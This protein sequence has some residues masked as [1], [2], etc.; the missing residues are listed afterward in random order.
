[1]AQKTIN[2]QPLEQ[3]VLTYLQ[4]H[5]MMSRGD[6]IVVAVSGG[7]DSVCL[8][9]ILHSLCPA[10]GIK[11]QVAHLDH[12][13]RGTESEADALYVAKLVK[14]L[15]IPATIEKRDVK[16]YRKRH[17]ISL[18]EA[19]REVRY[20]FLA[21]VVANTGAGCI[22]VGHTQNDNVETIL[23]HLIRGTGM[24][25]LRGLQP[26]TRWKLN[27][28]NLTVVRP[29][30]EIS[31]EE[32]LSYCARH[33]LHPR[34]DST[35]LSLAPLRN[36]IR[37]ELLP[38]LKRY[39][40]QVVTAILRTAHLAGDDIA[41]LEKHAAD[42]WRRVASKQ[43]DS[44][45]LDKESLR[46]LHPSL[47][48]YI[49]RLALEKQ[50]GNLKDIEAR[51]VEELLESFN[52]PAGKQISLPYGLVFSIDYD[53]YILAKET[54][55]LSP[56]P[57]I[58]GEYPVNIPGQ[59]VVPGWY[60]QADIMSPGETIPSD[61]NFTAY[62]DFSRTGK[63]L[64]IRPR[65]R[66]DR[67]QPLGMEETKK[68][69]DFMLDARISKDWRPHVPILCAG[70]KVLWVSGYRISESVKITNRT[71]QILRIKLERVL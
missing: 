11:L 21:E 5:H 25:G 58:A 40:P 24:R 7:P 4:K 19:A 34:Q 70:N 67:F 71:K 17:K 50:V 52:S 13:I 26:V 37:L 62:F 46:R 3:R 16:M 38:L 57:V 51:H 6:T 35:N 55:A 45:I 36:R 68:L 49:L 12:L 56:F 30:L 59:T 22:A 44:I 8:L 41:Y 15:S 23:L 28:K 31:R 18:E 20:N 32:T 10:L 53:R 2:K 42:L 54:S 66:G 43:G 60:L 33:R 29:L 69:A 61:D 65:K 47:Q 14:K 63:N 1:M 9:H 27:E 39:N 64:T 48:R